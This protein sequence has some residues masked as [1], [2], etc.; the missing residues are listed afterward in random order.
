MTVSSAFFRNALHRAGKI[1]SGCE[2]NIQHGRLTC[3]NTEQGAS[4]NRKSEK[5]RRSSY[6]FCLPFFLTLLW[7][8]AATDTSRQIAAPADLYYDTAEADDQSAA[9]QTP[10]E[11]ETTVAEELRELAKLGI[12]TPQTRYELEEEVNYDFPMAM[13]KE[14]EFYL[15]FFQN[16]QRKLFSRWL[17]RSTRYLPMIKEELRGAGLPEDLAYLPLIE[18]GYSLTAFSTAK[19][20]GPWQFMRPT[21]LDYGLEINKYVDERRDPEKSTK[22][23]VS[24]LANLYDM[25]GDWHLAVA[26][27]NAGCGKIKKGLENY[28]T[29]DFWELAQQQYL[30]DETKHFVPKLIA[31]IMIAKNPEKYGFTGIN[32]E[33]PLAYETVEVPAGTSLLAVQAACK[34]DLETLR[35]LNRQ[36]PQLITPPGAETYTLKVPVGSKE[37]VLANLP[38]VRPTISVEYKTHVVEN[39]GETLTQ[40]CALY[41]VSKTTLLKANNLR[42]S[43]L[44]VGQRLQIPTRTTN[45]VV[46]DES[47]PALAAAQPGMVLHEV[48]A[49]ETLSFICRRYNVPTEMVVAWNNLANADSIKAGQLLTLHVSDPTAPTLAAVE[50]PPEKKSAGADR[51]LQPST[52]TVRKGDTLWSIS[53]RFNLT[54]E[55]I[56]KW[57]D[58]RG[59]VIQPGTVLQVSAPAE[60]EVVSMIP[61]KT[62]RKR[63][64]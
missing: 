18:S 28:Q 48:K 1:L 2:N 46:M 53:Q 61:G 42:T 38:R 11:P 5:M 13:N 3:D 57:N 39:R 14:V 23:A 45:Y 12:W 64:L 41:N 43:K 36:L 6:I 29:N 17:E 58:I 8:C 10:A 35:N 37:M 21:A 44:T 15:D 49:G 16:K 33:P 63:S 24:L 7:G 31:A 55:Q 59:S 52:Y 22:A 30:A 20:V 51:T 25:F 26:A 50:D 54:P 27:Y 34:A 60:P 62:K 32:Y 9:D 4:A 40:I 19:A 56:R 47:S